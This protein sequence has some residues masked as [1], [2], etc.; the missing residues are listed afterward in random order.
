MLKH[1]TCLK[2]IRYYKNKT[3]MEVVGISSMYIIF[4]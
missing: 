3:L 2:I 4:F 1:N